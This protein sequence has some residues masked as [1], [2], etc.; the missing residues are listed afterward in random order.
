M[1]SA[2]II[3]RNNQATLTACLKS[4]AFA[5]ERLVIDSGSTDNTIPLAIELGARIVPHSWEGYGAQKNFG[6][7]QA[8]GD[9]LLFIDADEEVTVELREAIQTAINTA[10]HDFLWL[11]IVTVFLGQ[12]LRALYGH[13]LRLFR[14]DAGQWTLDHVHEQVQTTTG[15][16]LKLGDTTSTLLPG[17]LLHHSHDTLRSYLTKMQQYTTLE[18]KEMQQTNRHRSGRPV[19]HSWLLPW[20]LS[21]RQLIKLVFYRHGWKDGWA[22]IVWCLVSAYY[23]WQLGYKFNH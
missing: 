13:N 20:H 8:K 23:E 18:A 11:R 7:S 14:K 12:P 17:I 6:A 19:T 10:N 9:W 15:V 16:R 2:I 22:G 1:L 4:L 3:T 5:D 21:F